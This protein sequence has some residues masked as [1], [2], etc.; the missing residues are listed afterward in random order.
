MK[1]CEEN[2]RNDGELSLEKEE[3]DEIKNN[4]LS[5]ITFVDDDE[6]LFNLTRIFLQIPFEYGFD[7]ATDKKYEACKDFLR[8]NGFKV[9]KWLPIVL[10]MARV[11]IRES[12]KSK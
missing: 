5:Q 12:K 10:Q 9:K 2:A 7:G 3:R 8:W 4:K 1:W 11:W 6:E